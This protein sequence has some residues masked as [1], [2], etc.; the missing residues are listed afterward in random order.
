[1][2]ISSDTTRSFLAASI[3]IG[4]AAVVVLGVIFIG[5]GSGQNSAYARLTGAIDEEI[6]K[7]NIKP[8]T[9]E[10]TSEKAARVQLA[11]KRGD[12]STARQITADVLAN[13][14]LENW[15]YYPFSDFINGIVDVG[16]AALEAH[17]NA[18]VAQSKND[19]IPLLIRAQHYYQMGWSKRGHRFAHE[20][21][22]AS[23]AAFAVYMKKGLADIDAAIHLN[24]AIPYEFY[25]KLRILQG[26][27]MSQEMKNAFEEAIAKYPGYYPLYSLALNTLEPRWG[28]TVKAMYAFVDQ[29]AGHAAEFS[30]LKL[31]HLSLYRVLLRSASTACGSNRRDKDKMAQCVASE[32]QKNITP[33]LEKQVTAALQ[34]YDHSDKYQF[35]VAVEEIIFEM[36]NTTG[37][38]VYS[39]AFLELAA[40]GMHSNTQLKQDRPG[41]NNYVIDRA[42]SESWYAKDFYDNALKKDQQALKDIEVTA[43]PTEEEKDLAI[44]AIYGHL[45]KVSDNLHQYADMAAYE[46]AAIALSGKTTNEHFICY[47]YYQ[48][49]NY[50][51]ALRACT[52]A[53]EHDAGNLKARY[54]RSHVY[55]DLEQMDAA[56]QDSTIVADSEDDFR[57][58]A[59]ID[60]SMNYFNRKDVRGSLNVLNK[61]T[62]LYDPD[63]ASKEDMAVGYNNR[64]YAYMQL[65][66]LKKALD[67][68]TASLKYGSL[69]DAFR[70]Q[71]ELTKRLRAHETG[72]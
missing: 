5:R 12:Y 24:D 35:G 31:L 21:S 57:S 47:A 10:L 29:Y 4:V 26:F 58:R 13:S 45:A 62:Y 20:T 28:G 70:K 22:A 27:G 41:P 50:D 44:A 23:M 40:S 64:C 32:M 51:H 59:A 43:F 15:R 42:V 25:L 37:G 63:L 65:G 66:E 6:A 49:K 56:L 9:V 19:A 68:C 34:L 61:Y 38:D 11:I 48:L 69:P 7:L 36:L 16:D 71:M 60:M 17:L 8:R 1:L 55:R 72:L 54:W 30:P 3:A 39:G 33:E 2:D 52:K 14:R 18:W 46:E 67:D 53:I